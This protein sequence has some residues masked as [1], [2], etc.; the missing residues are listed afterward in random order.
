MEDVMFEGTTDFLK[1]GCRFTIKGPS[2]LV[3]DRSKPFDPAKF[4]G[5]GC[6]V[7]RGPRDGKGLEGDEAQDARSL[8]LAEIDFS[9]VRFESGLIKSESTIVG[10]EKLVRLMA[11]P[12]IR[13]DAKFGQALYEESGQATLCFLHEHFGVSWLEF[14]GTV[15]RHSG[16]GRYFLCLDRRVDGSWNWRYYWL[17]SDRARDDVSPLLA[18]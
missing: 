15:L 3:I 5:D 12:E 13:L 10:E 18:S 11:M 6:S 4:V 17:D 1:N 7:W 9:R 16:G 2:V 14:A 8:A